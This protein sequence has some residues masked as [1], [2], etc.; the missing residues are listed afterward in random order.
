MT[1]FTSISVVTQS[2]NSGV[3]NDEGVRQRRRKC[4]PWVVDKEGA[5]PPFIND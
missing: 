1:S 4:I 2:V 5:G 3:G